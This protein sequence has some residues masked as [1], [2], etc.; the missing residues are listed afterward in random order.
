MVILGIALSLP[1]LLTETAPIATWLTIT[2]YALVVI[3]LLIWTTADLDLNELAK[4]YPRA[5]C[6]SACVIL[7]LS[8]FQVAGN[9][10]L[11]VME[12]VPLIYFIIASCSQQNQQAAR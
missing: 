9:T 6:S 7:L 11:V 8:L 10:V 4:E 1:T 3:G 12:M 2:S 5:C